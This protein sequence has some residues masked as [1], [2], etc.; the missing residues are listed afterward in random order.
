ML[1]TLM[2]AVW[3]FLAITILVA[4]HEYGH[5]KVARLCGVKVLRFSIG[6]GR[7]LYSW[8][9]SKGTEY[10]LSAIPLGGYVKM[11]DEREASVSEKERAFAYNSK[12]PWQRI[13]IAAAGPLANFLLALAAYWILFLNG[14][15]VLT[16]VV[17]VV[18]PGSA[19]AI[20]GLE[21]GQEIVSVDGVS[22]DSRKDVQLRLLERLGQS[23][24]IEFVVRYPKSAEGDAGLSQN[25]TYQAIVPIDEWLKG[26]E[27]PNML[28][29]LGF[30]FYVPP[31]SNEI[32][33]V[34]EGGAAAS[35]G[36]KKGDLLQAIDGVKLDSEFDWL[37]YIATN[38]GN[39]LTFSIIREEESLDLIITP[40]RFVTEA[41]DVVGRIGIP[42][43][44][45]A[46]PEAMIRKK[47]YNLLQAGAAAVDNVQETA[48]LIL[49]SL[50]K[51]VVG[52]I[53]TKNLSGPIGIAQVAADHAEH[54]FL[55]FLDFLAYLSLMLG[56]INLLPIPVLDG[57][58]I[59]YSTIEWIKGSPVSERFQAV[60]QQ[61]GLVLILG[62]MLVAFYNDILRL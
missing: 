22:T 51:L 37:D 20:A 26:V 36:L 11:L 17:G 21:S 31:F 10:A 30:E 5:F 48:Q 38:P 34:S 16:P 28:E 18:E 44:R 14:S 57:G 56:V 15:T 42:V 4:V 1:D 62:L 47:E 55:S 19:A 43:M 9:D 40:K 33:G 12:H 53:S 61:F 39:S 2:T 45:E 32:A 52:E 29:S 60:A 58:H 24:H 46:Y 7:K 3:F 50:K 6:F 27:E 13:A 54:G 49:L 25:L 8:T 23:G 41:G 35:A 59:V